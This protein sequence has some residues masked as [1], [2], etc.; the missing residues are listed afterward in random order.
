MIQIHKLSNSK[1][2]TALDLAE[3]WYVNWFGGG[4]TELPGMEDFFAGDVKMIS[5]S[6]ARNSACV[7]INTSQ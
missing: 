3:D 7:V 1:T 2:R 5:F 6:I 4:T